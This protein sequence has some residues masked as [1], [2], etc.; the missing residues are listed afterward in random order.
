MIL[1]PRPHAKVQRNG[2]HPNES[3]QNEGRSTNNSLTVP[4]QSN[5]LA[6]GRDE[7]PHPKQERWLILIKMSRPPRLRITGTRTPTFQGHVTIRLS[8]AVPLSGARNQR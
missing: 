6:L 1:H 2:Y 7:D 8:R 5:H 4:I 3:R